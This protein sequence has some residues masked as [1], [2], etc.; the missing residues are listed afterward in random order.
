MATPDMAEQLGFD[1]P[2]VAALGRDD[3]LVA[4]SNEIAFAMIDGWQTW[5][6]RKLLLTGPEGSG[7]THLS[8]VWAAL[9]GAD[10]ITACDLTAEMVPALAAGSVAVEDVDRIAGNAQAQRVLFHLHNLVL[11]ESNSLLLTGT[12]PPQAWDI[13][14]ADLASRLGG[15][16]MVAL[17]P[18]DDALL[19]AVL[20]KLFADRQLM[21][22]PDVIAYLIRRI[23]RSFAAARDVVSALD[24][25]SLARK[26]PVSR[27]LAADLLDKEDAAR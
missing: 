4:P 14:L 20:A 3:F 18:P 21:P 22:K 24:A 15:T 27:S 7:K 1:L 9:S 6:G 26:K 5:P 8:H 19:S 11:A 23:D 10:V 12:G 17:E 2:G 13:G 25:A 16:P